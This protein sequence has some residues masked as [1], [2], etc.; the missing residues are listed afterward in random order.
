[1][2]K[3]GY[4]IYTSLRR[5]EENP[6]FQNSD[7]AVDS[8]QS[9]KTLIPRIRIH[10]VKSFVSEDSSD[11]IPL[12]IGELILQQTVERLKKNGHIRDSETSK[13]KQV[14]EFIEQNENEEYSKNPE[15]EKTAESKGREHFQIESGIPSGSKNTRIGYYGSRRN[16]VILSNPRRSGQVG[17]F[18]AKS[19]PEGIMTDN[20]K[21]MFSI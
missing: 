9:Q 6:S 14:K 17:I 10:S 4:D 1:M 3:D 16:N 20:W 8:L 21:R 13:D 12:S 18:S 2:E 15:I 11:P 19:Q 7:E 5:K